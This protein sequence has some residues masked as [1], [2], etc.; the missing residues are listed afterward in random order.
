MADSEVDRHL[1]PLNVLY[2]L[3]DVMDDNAIIVADGGDFVGSAAYILR[4]AS[5]L[6]PPPL[7][8]TP[9]TFMLPRSSGQV[10]VLIQ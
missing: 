3:E 1:N 10:T 8:H 5:T 9:R 6:L 4:L 7:P 2:R